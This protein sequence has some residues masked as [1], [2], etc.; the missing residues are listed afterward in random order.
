[1]MFLCFSK[2]TSRDTV[3]LLSSRGWTTESKERLSVEAS[4]EMCVLA[5]QMEMTLILSQSQ[6]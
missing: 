2:I 6:T 3:P 5:K 4:V 1:M